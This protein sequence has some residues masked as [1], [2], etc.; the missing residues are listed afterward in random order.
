MTLIVIIALVLLILGIVLINK[1]E[2]KKGAKTV[3]GIAG[4]IK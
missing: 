4:A 1:D 3:A 2:I